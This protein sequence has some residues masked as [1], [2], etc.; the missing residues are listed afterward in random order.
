MGAEASHPL[1]IS[2]AVAALEFLFGL[3]IGLVLL[4]WQ[5]LR[6]DAKLE[7]LA[8]KLQPDIKDSPFSSASQLA[9]AISRQQ[10]FQQQLEQQL[11]VQRQILQI[12]PV[13]Y[14]QVDDENRFIWCNQ[15]A[16][17]LLGIT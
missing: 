17:K 16:Q 14:V 6:S 15:Q 11:E 13:G 8:Q 10:K 7:A 4:W 12:S 2:P 3:S 1:S 5:R 9:L